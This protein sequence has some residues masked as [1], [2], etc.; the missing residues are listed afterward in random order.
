MEDSGVVKW[1]FRGNSQACEYLAL[2]A[3]LNGLTTVITNKAK[4]IL[5]ITS[6][7][8]TGIW[9]SPPK[10]RVRSEMIMPFYKR[11]FL[12]LKTLKINC[13]VL[14]HWRSKTH[15]SLSHALTRQA[16]GR[17]H[18]IDPDMTINKDNIS[19]GSIPIPS[20]PVITRYLYQLATQE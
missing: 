16:F 18:N 14:F 19:T 8:Q 17:C 6:N 1:N 7:S 2:I 9:Q 13:Q 11:A 20:P 10:S 3:A 4:H 5:T 15:T 12:M